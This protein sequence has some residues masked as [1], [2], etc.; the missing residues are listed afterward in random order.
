M[1]DKRSA[2]TCAGRLYYIAHARSNTGVQ[3][4]IIQQA[5][6]MEIEP[7]TIDAEYDPSDGVK[8]TSCS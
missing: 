2:S 7:R 1:V 4:R 3:E 5:A 8:L 6:G